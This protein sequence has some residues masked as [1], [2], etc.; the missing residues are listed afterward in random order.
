MD[1]FTDSIQKKKKNC[2]LGKL[3]QAAEL[4][5]KGMKLN[6]HATCMEGY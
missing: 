5:T 4:K 2:H 3:T 1:D 6:P